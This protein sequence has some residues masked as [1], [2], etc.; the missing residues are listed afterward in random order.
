M[1]H[2]GFAA[3]RLQSIQLDDAPAFGFCI[4]ASALF[5]VFRALAADLILRRNADPDADVFGLLRRGWHRYSPL[6]GEYNAENR[7]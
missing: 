2:Y 1:R 3:Y 5:V 6:F 7:M 4:C